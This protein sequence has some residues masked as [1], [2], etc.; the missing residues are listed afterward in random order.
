MIRTW[1]DNELKLLKENYPKMNAAQLR[2]LLPTK[3]DSSIKSKALCL[4]IHKEKKRFEFTPE[5]VKLITEL[6]P[7]TLSSEIAKLIGCSLYSLYNK[8]AAL[9]LKKDASFVVELGKLS[10]K[11]A[12]EASISSRFKPGHIPANKGKK[13]GADAYNKCKHTM[14]KKGHCP[15]NH[16][17]IGHERITRDGYIEVKTAEPNVFEL[18][19]RLVYKEHYGEIPEGFMVRFKNGNRLDVS[20]DNLF[21]MSKSENMTENTIHRYPTEVKRAIRTINKLTRKINEYETNKH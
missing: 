14:F 2:N 13:M 18:K 16:K 9:N 6:Y 20:P 7:N 1:S 4:N 17:P 19:H 10:I 15:A 12:G 21:L 5:A 3:T 11:K 8:A